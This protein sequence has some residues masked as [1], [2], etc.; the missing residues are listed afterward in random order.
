MAV[1]KNKDILFIHEI[2]GVA[3][4]NAIPVT[5]GSTGPL[6]PCHVLDGTIY[7][8]VRAI[9]SQDD[10]HDGRADISAPYQVKRVLPDHSE[11]DTLIMHCLPA[12]R[13]EKITDEL[14]ED[15]RSIAFDEAGNHLY[16]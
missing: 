6:Q 9:M 10:D 8:S 4:Q 2:E 14:I 13:G 11:A 3:A 1:K 12:H 5:S 15:R 16:I 7:I